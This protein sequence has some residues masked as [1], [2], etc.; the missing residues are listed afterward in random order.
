M[1]ANAL[2]YVDTA[3]VLQGHIYTTH[4]Q[5]SMKVNMDLF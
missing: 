4:G 1:P 2:I 5:V 3:V